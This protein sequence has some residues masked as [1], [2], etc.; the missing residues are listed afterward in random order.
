[1]KAEQSI[2]FESIY[3]EYHAMVRQLCLGYLKGNASQANDLCQEVF[4]NIW[5][6]IDQFNNQST[7]KTWIYRIT[8][9]TCLQ[10]LRKEKS[11]KKIA[12]VSP[13]AEAAK[14]QS[15]YPETI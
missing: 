15:D 14:Q 9:N 11:R 7:L 3:H 8:V 6:S 12:E 5:N 2:R 10:F 4:I 13:N 1:M